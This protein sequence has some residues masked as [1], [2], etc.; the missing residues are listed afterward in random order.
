MKRLLSLLLAVAFVFAFA[1]CT[2]DMP[3]NKKTTQNQGAVTNENQDSK[4]QTENNTTAPNNE[5][6]SQD[7]NN[8]TEKFITV[9]KAKQIAFADAKVK[10]SQIRDFEMELDHEGKTNYYEI[11]FE[12]GGIEY[13]YDIDAKSGKILKKHKEK[14]D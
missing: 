8:Y 4:P 3:E 14:E 12:A 13:E 6:P 2:N 9:A 5:K 10:E 7:S 11:N 1:G